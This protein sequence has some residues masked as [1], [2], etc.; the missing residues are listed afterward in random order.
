MDCPHNLIVWTQPSLLSDCLIDA[1][2]RQTVNSKAAEREG[3]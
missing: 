1:V 3:K 2:G